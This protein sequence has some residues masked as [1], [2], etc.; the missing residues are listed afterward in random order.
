M[1]NQKYI[2]N[3]KIED[4]IGKRFNSLTVVDFDIDKF[5]FDKERLK[6][7]EIK[8]VSPYWI[9]RCDCGNLKSIRQGHL[10]QSKTKS[11]GC[12]NSDI[13]SERSSLNFNF[14]FEDWCKDN[15]H[16]DYL[17]L[18]DYELNDKKPNEVGCRSRSCFY[19]KCQKGLHDSEKKQIMIFTCGDGSVITCK[20]CRSFGQYLLD[21][22]GGDGINM[23]WGDKNTFDAFSVNAKCNKK[24]WI[25]CQEHNHEYH[26]TCYSFYIGTRC[27]YCNGNMTL[28][29]FNDISTTH[30]HL[31]K[32]FLNPEDAKENRISSNKKVKIVCPECGGIK[33]TMIC[34]FSKTLSYCNICCDG[35]SYP[36][37]IATIMLKLLGIDFKTEYAPSWAIDN[38]GAHRR[39]DF[40]IPSKKL[41]IEMDGGFHYIDNKMT[42]QTV[43]EV[44]SIDLWKDN[45][46]LSHGMVVIRINCVTSEFEYIKHSIITSELK[47]IIDIDTVD[48]DMVLKKSTESFIKKTC[49]LWE[50]M[51]NTLDIA[52][53][54]GINRQTVVKYLK[55]GN[56]LGLCNYDPSEQKFISGSYPITVYKNGTIIYESKSISELA[57]NSEEVFGKRLSHRK[58]KSMSSVTDGNLI[59]ILK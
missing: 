40:Y 48:W 23:Y 7:G 54:V 5:N 22:Y 33:N 25:K 41:I 39:Y 20:K 42:G 6:N 2:I 30:P 45:Q 1:P 34:T 18:W 53:E 47:N 37:K 46:A 27:S 32:Y 29:G 31:V 17:D 43:E 4:L 26:A 28:Y 12:Y 19:F 9:C 11:C 58:I 59:I 56:S 21:T 35:I 3:T 50:T 52:F 16:Q 15:N 51:K 36:E 10:K 44:R 14:S 38:S 57:R 55:I 49:S 24:V 8:V 13:T